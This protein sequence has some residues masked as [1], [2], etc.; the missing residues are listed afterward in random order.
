[1][2]SEKIDIIEKKGKGIFLLILACI[3]IISPYD[4]IPEAILKNIWAYA[5]DILVF[6]LACIKSYNMGKK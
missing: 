5:D 4:V 1:M 6:I 3:Y 2:A